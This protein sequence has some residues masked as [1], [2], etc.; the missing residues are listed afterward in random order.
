VTAAVRRSRR[1]DQRA[2]GGVARPAG[3]RRPGLVVGLGVAITILGIALASRLTIQTDLSELLPPRAP[4]VIALHALAGRVGG[5]GNVAIA[6]ESVDGSPQRLRGYLPRL[7]GALRAALGRDAL[8]IRYSRQP[9]TDYYARFAIYYAPL[10]DLARWARALAVALAKQNPAYVEL[11]DDAGDPLRAL[12]ADVRATRGA[13]G[14]AEQAADDQTGLLMTERGRLGV[15]FVRPASGSLDLGGAGHMMQRI[16]EIVAATRPAEA[17][18]RIAG[19]TGSIPL[20]IGEVEAIEHDLVSTAILVVLGVGAAV[21]VFFRSV[22]ELALM[23][24]AVIVGTAV[25]LGFAAVWIG[26]VNAQ[27]AFLGAIIAAPAVVLASLTSIIGYAS[28]ITADSQA[29]ASFGALAVIGELACVA[30]AIVV[31]PA[32]WALGRRR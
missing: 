17:G 8:S 28:L 30:V 10:G 9:I 22:R 19:Y 12:A 13:R 21:L 5:T 32:L 25:A 7:A 29:L 2:A 31:V 14:S 20:A 24:G 16:A 1:D 23:S 6:V 18:V 15:V 4:S 27:T 11:D 3:G 26:H